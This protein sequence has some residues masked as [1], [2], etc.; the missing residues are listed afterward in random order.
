MSKG[1]PSPSPKTRFTTSRDEPLT[2]QMQ[3]RVTESMWTRL[4]EL[5]NW[6]EIVRFAIAK[7]LNQ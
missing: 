1:N 3:L 2:K 6:Q 5:D 7:E 4:Q